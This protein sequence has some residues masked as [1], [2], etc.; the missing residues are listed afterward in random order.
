MVNFRD[1]ECPKDLVPKKTF[2][3]AIR[4]RI[5]PEYGW[6]VDYCSRYNGPPNEIFTDIEEVKA[7][8]NYLGPRHECKI[9]TWELL[10]D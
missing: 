2:A 7:Y 8:I 10:N 9:L 3:V 1:V 5:H 6:I 4:D